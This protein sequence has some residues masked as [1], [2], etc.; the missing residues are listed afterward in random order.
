[1][2]IKSYTYDPFLSK[3]SFDL[4]DSSDDSY[5]RSQYFSVM[6]RLLFEYKYI[7]ENH[8]LCYFVT[9]TYNDSSVF[10]LDGMNVLYNYHIREFFNKSIFL[11]RMSQHGYR[12][13]YAC[14]SE[15][16]DGKGKRGFD[17]NPH[18]HCLV[19]LVPDNCCDLFYHNDSNFL[20][21]CN[22]CWNSNFGTVSS[23]RDLSRGIVSYS[24]SGAVVNSP[25]CFQYC[26]SYCVKKLS[27]F[28]Y[29]K[30]LKQY[31]YKSTFYTLMSFFSY[32]PQ[33]SQRYIYPSVYTSDFI[34]KFLRRFNSSYG[35][36]FPNISSALLASFE[37][38]SVLPLDVQHIVD[39]CAASEFVHSP[40]VRSLM[41][42]KLF[43]SF[44]RYL[45]SLH[46]PSYSLSH[47][48][49]EYGL[50][51]ITSDY[52][53]D[54]SSFE[55]LKLKSVRIPSYFYRKF[56]YDTFCIDVKK[57][58][59]YVSVSNAN[60]K[61]YLLS[62]YSSERFVAYCDTVYSNRF[63][64]INYL[65]EHDEFLVSVFKSIPIHVFVK[66]FPLRYRSYHRSCPPDLFGF[67]FQLPFLDIVHSQETFMIP[68]GLSSFPDFISYSQHSLFVDYP[69]LDELVAL[70]FTF[71]RKSQTLVHDVTEFHKFNK[72]LYNVV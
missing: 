59:T 56:F 44:F 25:K 64:F 22:K 21:L 61:S 72:P 11:R 54:V 60:Y 65:S 1:M 19:F 13:R 31:L 37:E 41:N 36:N 28:S 38:C 7:N 42:T 27:D 29:S 20:N 69:R 23:Y 8:G 5:L 26:S 53:L 32:V 16:G 4:P 34:V 30:S 35:F 52:R 43:L 2:D 50:N 9:F 62:F 66:Y 58:K 24:K 48:L 51:F 71:V 10:H 17:N 49:G 33:K 70:W 39:Y 45:C 15:L 12:F 63:S 3:S 57:G 18:Y 6:C 46:C 47:S 55:V 14:F 68:R 67:G 40:L